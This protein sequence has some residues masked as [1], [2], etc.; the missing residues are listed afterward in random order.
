MSVFANAC[1]TDATIHISIDLVHWCNIKIVLNCGIWSTGKTFFLSFLKCIKDL[2]H[3]QLPGILCLPA[4]SHR[5][6]ELWL[7]RKLSLS[8]HYLHQNDLCTWVIHHILKFPLW[9]RLSEI[10]KDYTEQQHKSETGNKT[11]AMAQFLPNK[12]WAKWTIN[13]PWSL[14]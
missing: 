3:S 11:I 7:K 14:F 5:L 8:A 12:W 6:N 2:I 4:I 10:L 1:S 9:R 13:L